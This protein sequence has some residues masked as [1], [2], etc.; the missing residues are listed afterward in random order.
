MTG[1]SVCMKSLT[2]LLKRARRAYCSA[3]PVRHPAIQAQRGVLARPGR[4]ERAKD[5]PFECLEP[6]LLP[7]G[8]GPGTSAWAAWTWA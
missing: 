1:L 6:T 8:P 3:S 5:S 2:F 7:A 4:G